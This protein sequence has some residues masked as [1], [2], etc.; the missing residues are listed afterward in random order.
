[1]SW[2]ESI[3]N[4]RE[5]YLHSVLEKIT[6]KPAWLDQDEIFV[7]IDL[8]GLHYSMLPFV[9][10]QYL[11]PHHP[12]IPIADKNLNEY[13]AASTRAIF[14]SHGEVSGPTKYNTIHTWISTSDSI[15]TTISSARITTLGCWSAL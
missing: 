15:A 8:L 4:V 1:M 3:L 13:E 6:Y 5:D 10:G 7:L 2:T 11:G 9:A 14:V 12:S